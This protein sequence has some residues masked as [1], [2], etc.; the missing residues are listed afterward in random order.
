M[1]P[2]PNPE[3]STARA[4]RVWRS[5][6]M[7]L[8]LLGGGTLVVVMAVVLGSSYFYLHGVMRGQIHDHLSSV[9]YGRR[10][11]VQTY[12]RFHR[13]RLVVIA[14]RVLVR[15]C[16][17]DHAAQNPG[18][19]A[20]RGLAQE[21]LAD[22]DALLPHMLRIRVVD[23]QGTVVVAHPVEASGSSAAAEPAFQAGLGG[24]HLSLPTRRAERYEA[25]FA[26]PVRHEG[27]TLGVLLVT[28]DMTPLEEMI[29][30]TTGLGK[31]GEVVLEVRQGDDAW[32]LF[33]AR[34][35]DEPFV[36]PLAQGAMM[37]AALEGREFFGE[38]L[39][40][41]GAKVLAAA[42]PVGDDGW[43]LVAKLDMNEAYAPLLRGAYM[44]LGLGLA[45]SLI[46]LP[47]AW[48]LVRRV[49]RPLLQLIEAA[50]RVARGDLDIS[51][52]VTSET[53]VGELTA[54]FTEMT[55][56]SLRMRV[57][58]QEN[59][60]EQIRQ[61]NH[62]LE[63]RV[64][65]RVEELATQARRLA[66]RDVEV[67]QALRILMEEK[68]TELALISKYKSEFLASMSHELRTPLNSVLVLGQHL[69][70]NPDGNLT[71]KQ[72]EF[73]R[74]IHGAGADLLILINDILDLSK[75]ES[76]TVSVDVEE[77]SFTR[78]VEVVA[79]PFRY[80]AE[81]RGL[82]FD[83]QLDPSLG[84]HLVTDSKRLQQVLRNL[85]SNAIKFTEQGGV[86]L[87]VA[88]AGDWSTDHL[89]L[90]GVASVVAFE[91]SDTGIGI[92]VGKQKIIFEAFRQA[93][94]GT[95]RKYGGT[96]LGLA[97]SRELAGLLGGEI[98]LRSTPG[99]GST[100]T[101]Y[102]PQTYVDPAIALERIR[103]DASLD[104]VPVVVKDVEAPER[105]LDK[106]ALF[107]HRVVDDLP[108]EKQRL[109]DR[110]HHSDDD[111]MGKKVLVVDDDVRNLFVL[112]SIL[113]S[114]SMIVLTA[115]TGHEA[116]VILDQTPDLAIVLM[117]IMMPEMD[118]YETM[119]VIRRNPAFRRL[120]IIALTAKAMIGDRKKC[121]ESGASDYLAKPVDTEQLLSVLRLWLHRL[122][123]NGEGI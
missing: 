11:A 48:V 6:T 84:G 74:T 10:V 85:L 86:R 110:L 41:R 88:A 104:D 60:E 112:S 15:H 107:L 56:A 19:E 73:V 25:E 75:I 54:R 101:L 72:V 51:V 77:V 30:D 21:S 45:G 96:G 91:V 95:S 111:L 47:V 14:G 29:R 57:A 68:I 37:A 67:E 62:D 16:L 114:H 106:T 34:G 42:G 109:L 17:A 83:V 70:E 38:A 46:G 50:E 31:S 55:V 5:L 105:L 28:T 87:R 9:A 39:D 92:P 76:G 82:T 69:S 80:E 3:S 58:E 89:V 78:L 66:E 18:A 116:I 123:E 63:Q 108:Q 113:E 90:K 27:R 117:D 93:D 35:R 22:T 79:R 100:F 94:A 61:L 36:V 119:Q 13:E 32:S 97:I 103:D 98:Q 33:P 40:Q 52:P 59:V 8:M 64:A 20:S 71:P 118:G 26:A 122:G 12:L 115:G 7:Q 121:M 53:E 81:N 120:P 44:V 1:N 24:V 4:L 49:T 102:L 43:G 99:S 65:E 2:S 23:R